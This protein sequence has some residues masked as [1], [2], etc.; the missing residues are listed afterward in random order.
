MGLM[1]YKE[2]YVN[3]AGISL[4]LRVNKPWDSHCGRCRDPRNAETLEMQTPE[5]QRPQRAWGA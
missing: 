1:W 5:M 3:M 4:K 2:M